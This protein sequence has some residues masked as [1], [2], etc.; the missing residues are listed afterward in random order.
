MHIPLRQ[1]WELLLVYLRPQWRRVL[2][3][4]ALILGNIGLQLVNPQIVRRFIDAAQT[5]STGGPLLYAALAF[6]AV[7]LV[8]Q[9]AGI[10]ATYVGEN[11]G[12]STT[13]ALRA[14]LA[15]H[16]LRL[17]LSFHSAHTPGEMIERL[18]GDVTALANFFSQFA[19]QVLGNALLLGG[20]LAMLCR[21]DRRVGGVLLAFAL[22]A[23]AILGRVRGLAV[24]H[25]AAERQASA[26][27]F[28]FL[29]ERLAGTEDI[30]ACGAGEYV[31]RQF[32]VLMRQWM[33][34]ALRAGA[35]SSVMTNATAT[36]VLV[37]PTV[38]L[39]VSAAL[40]LRGAFTV[41]SVYLVFFYA[42]MLT[43]PINQITV[44]LQ[45]LQRA[46]ASVSRVRE[47]LA[48]P[49]IIREGGAAAAM[50]TAAAPRRAPAVA[51]ERV[52]FGYGRERVLHDLTF[53][54]A[55]GQVLG[56][57][58]RT[59]SGKSTL[60]RLLFRFYDPDE[61]HIRLGDGRTDIRDLPLAAL[62]Q[63][64][65]L[66]TQEIQ[67]FN[68]SVRDNLTFFASTCRDGE[69]IRVLRELGL[70]PWVASLPQGLDTILGSGAS[71]LSAGQAQLL[72]FARVFLQDPGLVILDEASSRLDPATE[73]LVERAVDRLV[74]G[75]TAIIIAHRL[76]T[77]QR[78]GEIMIL[79]EGHIVECG[80]RKCLAADPSSRF[81]HLLQTGM[82]EVL[83]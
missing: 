50:P 68:A 30:R 34:K 39:A 2:L 42:S 8:Q 3:L 6:I 44:Q 7:A 57:L 82:E 71:G 27:L 9:G 73:Q 10:A 12:W 76:G 20:V 65:G 77:V 62:R 54:L 67:L 46:G 63:Q 49:S 15:A 75:R 59:G 21:E 56:L 24:P 69:I 41:G 28:G 38:A 22:V 43:M 37:A 74:Y 33:H 64:V 72:A 1:Y 81:Y 51:F 80:A 19:I 17:D 58:G 13:N 29:E 55:P 47:L 60:I 66:V 35:L 31:L 45:D 70:E 32:A 83:A 4:G 53:D 11:V 18:D 36:L 16:C 23:F 78:A 26:E 40:Y 61:G 25:W 48:T 52:S 5:G 14:D 79:E